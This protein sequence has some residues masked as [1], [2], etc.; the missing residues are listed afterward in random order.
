MTPTVRAP[1][2]RMRPGV[3]RD[4]RPSSRFDERP[5]PKSRTDGRDGLFTTV[6][7]PYSV[8]RIGTSQPECLA[9]TL[10]PRTAAR[11]RPSSTTKP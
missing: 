10:T 9:W 2:R 11:W 4:A 5:V 1:G 7:A 3:M 8:G 6:A